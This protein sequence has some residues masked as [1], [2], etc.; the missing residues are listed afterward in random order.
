M[1]KITRDDWSGS[2]LA[3]NSAWMYYLADVVRCCPSP[4]CCA[5]TCKLQPGKAEC[6]AP[7][8]AAQRAPCG[9]QGGGLKALAWSSG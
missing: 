3:T 7:W 2:H 8:L 6:C 4:C 5:R 1:R 9:L